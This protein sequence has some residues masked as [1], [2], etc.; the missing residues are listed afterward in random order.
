MEQCAPLWAG[1]LSKKSA[2]ALSRVEKNAM[3]IIFPLKNPE[4]SIQRLGIKN[5]QER[6]ICLT[7]RFAI[8]MFSKLMNE[9][10]EDVFRS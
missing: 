7:K 5:L 6:R 3:K 2:K 10:T 9:Q 1:N 4:E 8:K